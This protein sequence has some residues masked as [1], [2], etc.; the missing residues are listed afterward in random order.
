MSKPRMTLDPMYDKAGIR[1]FFAPELHSNSRSDY[2][3]KIMSADIE[4]MYDLN[5]SCGKRIFITLMNG[6]TVETIEETISYLKD[7]IDNLGKNSFY[8]RDVVYNLLLNNKCMTRGDLNNLL[9][10]SVY[11]GYEIE[12]VLESKLISINPSYELF[13]SVMKLAKLENEEVRINDLIRMYDNIEAG[14]EDVIINAY[15]LT[16]KNKFMAHYNFKQY[17]NGRKG[18]IK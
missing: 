11:E 3:A 9:E 7:L 15:P 13:Y 17:V 1:K 18:K 12:D 2:Y 8:L 16:S 14:K 5:A 10:L 6:A 4:K